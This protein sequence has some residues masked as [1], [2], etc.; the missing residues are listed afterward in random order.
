LSSLPARKA[1]PPAVDAE[2]GIDPATATAELE[3]ASDA[4]TTPPAAAENTPDLRM[5]YPKDIAALV[6][7]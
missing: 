7:R 3:A 6:E 4:D 5:A 2:E 1:F